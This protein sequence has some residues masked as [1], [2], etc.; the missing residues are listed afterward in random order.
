MSGHP[1]RENAEDSEPQCSSQTPPHPLPGLA[2]RQWLTHQ[3]RGGTQ[4]HFPLPSPEMRA[5]HSPNTCFHVPH[6]IHTYLMLL[7]VRHRLCLSKPRPFLLNTPSFPKVAHL[8]AHRLKIILRLSQWFSQF[9]LHLKRDIM[10]MF[11]GCFPAVRISQPCS[12]MKYG[13]YR[14]SEQ[15]SS[16][17]PSDLSPYRRGHS[18]FVEAAPG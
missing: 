14:S 16:C 7:V 11:S 17:L 8:K 3:R 10:Q 2:G 18:T 5:F 9:N 6:C 15:L 12:L 4:N 13:S 1:K